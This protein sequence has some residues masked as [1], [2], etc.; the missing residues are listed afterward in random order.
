[1]KR[2][3]SISEPKND[4]V[5]R[6]YFD[7]ENRTEEGNKFHYTCFCNVKRTAKKNC[8]YS[9]LLSHV[10]DAHPNYRQEV[11]NKDVCFTILDNVMTHIPES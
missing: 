5:V 6:F 2:K 3:A 8:G 1:M 4:D 11:T 10:K 9:N 7:F